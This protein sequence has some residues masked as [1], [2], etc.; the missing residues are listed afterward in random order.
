MMRS[1]CENVDGVAKRA[2]KSRSAAT[3]AAKRTYRDRLSDGKLNVYFCHACR[4][5]HVGHTFV[6]LGR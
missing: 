5:F 6:E 1:P 4:R 2:Y 3:R